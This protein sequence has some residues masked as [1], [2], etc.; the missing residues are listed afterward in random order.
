MCRK[1]FDENI[2][3]YIQLA[4][5]IVCELVVCVLNEF[6]KNCDNKMKALEGG[7]NIA[8]FISPLVFQYLRVHINTIYTL[9]LYT[10]YIRVE[11]CV[12]FC[13]KGGPKIFYC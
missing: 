9:C 12:H 11:I 3:I 6:I 7:V 10:R 2:Y 13:F 4:E 8:C 1:K 5:I